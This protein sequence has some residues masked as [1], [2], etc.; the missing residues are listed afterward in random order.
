[1]LKGYIPSRLISGSVPLI[2]IIINF[3]IFVSCN[4]SSLNIIKAPVPQGNLIRFSNKL[5]LDLRFFRVWS[6]FFLH[7]TSFFPFPNCSYFHLNSS[8]SLVPHLVIFII[9]VFL[10]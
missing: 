9:P 10:N 5:L 6:E 8:L 2:I 7:F 4:I 1:M 3:T